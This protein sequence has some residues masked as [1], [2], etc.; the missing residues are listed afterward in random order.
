LRDPFGL[1]ASSAAWCFVKGAAR[2]AAG[3]AVVGGIAVGVV[4]LG[5]PVA[6]VTVGLGAVAIAGTAVWGWNTGTDIANSNWN[7]LAYDVGSAVGGAV[8]AGVG[9]RAV[10]EGVNGVPS[11]PW[12]WSSDAAQHF[13]PNMGSVWDWFGTGPNPGSAAGSTAAGGAGSAMAG[14][15]CGCN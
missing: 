5:A 8:A 12:S 15:N 2:G 7:G 11:P 6:A 10:A 1:S 3:A 9:G 4:A 14:R 13:D